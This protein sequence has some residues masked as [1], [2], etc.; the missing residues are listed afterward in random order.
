MA[1]KRREH[2]L[3][4]NIPVK[5]SWEKEQGIDG[6]VCNISRLGA[7]VELNKQIP[8]GA[9]VGINMDIP[10]YTQDA[11]LTGN[12]SCSGTIFRSTPMEDMGGSAAYGVGIFFTDFA[13][14]LD[15]NKLSQYIYHL[16]I[17]E[18][19]GI[20]EGLRR[21]KEK[22]RMRHA[23]CS[24]ESPSA[25]GKNFQK[26][27]LTLLKQISCRLDNLEHLLNARKK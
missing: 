23:S 27:A 21:R 14:P 15:K 3:R 6:R 13:T 1:E 7:Y 26:E 16:T 24:R 18:E 20:K 9:S 11:S 4:A 2:R 17:E 19:A 8:P 22:A 25:R 5:L 12:I 10:A